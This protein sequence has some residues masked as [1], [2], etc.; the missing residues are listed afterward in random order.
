MNSH[1]FSEEDA[2]QLL[3]AKTD[4]SGEKD[5]SRSELVR[6]DSF[7]SFMMNFLIIFKY[8]IQY[9]LLIFHLA[10]LALGVS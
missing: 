7:L 3:K 10:L 1:S 4:V 8:D 9:I 5:I 6:G 2:S